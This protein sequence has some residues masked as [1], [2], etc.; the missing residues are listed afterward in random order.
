[1]K[2]KNAPVQTILELACSAYRTLDRQYIKEHEFWTQ[3]VDPKK[4]PTNVPN[5]LL[6]QTTLRYFDWYKDYMPPKDLVVTDED[7]KLADD[8]RTFYKRLAFNII[9]DDGSFE[10]TI[11]SLLNSNEML[12]S[13]AGFLAF[14]PEKYKKDLALKKIKQ[15]VKTCDDD[16]IGE[17]GDEIADIDG[18][19]IDISKSKNFDAFNVS[20]IVDNK[21]CS[22]MSNRELAI[23]PTVI[24]KARIK[25]HSTHWKYG[26]RITRLNY[27]KAVQ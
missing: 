13:N 9:A 23:G 14:L 2:E 5:K 24:V 27:V 22:W 10:A 20:A 6:I 1:M 17:V 15:E 4:T 18:E 19:I 26:N 16:Y 12:I 8:I 7:K 11:Y 3:E 25:E 21:M